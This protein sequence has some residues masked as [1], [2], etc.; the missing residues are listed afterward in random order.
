MARHRYNFTIRM[1]RLLTASRS[2]W[3]RGATVSH[4]RR[5]PTTPPYT[6]AGRDD[7]SARL[8]LRDQQGQSGK[9]R[10]GHSSSTGSLRRAGAAHELLLWSERLRAHADTGNRLLVP[11]DGVNDWIQVKGDP[12]PGTPTPTPTRLRRRFPLDVCADADA[13][14]RRRTEH[15]R[16]CIGHEEWSSGRIAIDFATNRLWV[17]GTIRI[18]H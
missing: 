10:T 4:R 18:E 17:V 7:N 15:G 14:P 13:E 8:I 16:R 3:W 11:L 5:Q 1:K 2:R 6:G 12:R 9:G